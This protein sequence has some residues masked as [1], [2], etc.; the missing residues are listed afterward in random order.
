MVGSRDAILETLARVLEI[1]RSFR[2]IIIDIDI[3]IVL[4]EIRIVVILTRIACAICMIVQL[5]VDPLA[6][7][8]RVETQL[9]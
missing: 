7:A 5:L 9:P 6:C 1:E 8:C 2:V 4:V 3:G